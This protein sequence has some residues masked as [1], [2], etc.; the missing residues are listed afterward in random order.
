[1]KNKIVMVLLLLTLTLSSCGPSK[2]IKNETDSQVMQNQ[3]K[4]SQEDGTDKVN[5]ETENSEW[6]ELNAAARGCKIYQQDETLKQDGLE[7]TVNHAEITKKHGNW[8]DQ[9]WE[10]DVAYDQNNNLTTDFSYFVVDATIHSIQDQEEFWWSNI[11]LNEYKPGDKNMGPN[12]LFTTD[13]ITQQEMETNKSCFQTKL[14]KDQEI[15]MVK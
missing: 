3:G 13:A 7:I 12:I 9:D 5:E 6:A 8:V 2:G 11:E 1:M 4:N 15:K 10:R 14:K